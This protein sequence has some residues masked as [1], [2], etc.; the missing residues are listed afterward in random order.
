MKEIRERDLTVIPE[1]TYGLTRVIFVFMGR[2]MGKGEKL[3][4]FCFVLF[5]IK[6][7]GNLV[8]GRQLS[9]ILQSMSLALNRLGFKSFIYWSCV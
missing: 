7:S 9:E 6:L 8:L 4:L 2:V 5:L 1:G 3:V